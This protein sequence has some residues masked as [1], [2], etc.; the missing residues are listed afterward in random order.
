LEES[1]H[2][3]AAIGDCV[4]PTPGIDLILA[5]EEPAS[6]LPKGTIIAACSRSP[7]GAKS[8]RLVDLPEAVNDGTAEIVRKAKV[9]Y[10]IL[11]P[12][13]LS[14]TLAKRRIEELQKA[15]AEDACTQILLNRWHPDSLQLQDIQDTLGRGICAVF[16]NNYRR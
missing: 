15:G 11:N 1:D 6:Y 10:I 8:A 5:G 16:P 12:G 2:L 4:I 14:L 7:R 9:T 3:D 13:V